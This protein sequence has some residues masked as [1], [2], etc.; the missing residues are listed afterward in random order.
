M[1]IANAYATNW[2]WL[3]AIEAG[4]Y[5][6]FQARK[7]RQSH[8]GKRYPADFSYVLFR[9]LLPRRFTQQDTLPGLS[10]LTGFPA[11]SSRYNR[12]TRSTNA[13]GRPW[14]ARSL[15]T[16]RTP[17]V[18]STHSPQRS[19][20]YLTGVAKGKPPPISPCSCTV[21]YRRSISTHITCTSSS[22]STPRPISR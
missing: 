2:F 4:L 11:N 12:R 9:D 5:E 17:L 21:R 8:I 1:L 6:H 16:F 3:S 19:R 18:C 14:D 7:A 13:K 10:A 22:G 15:T 20:R